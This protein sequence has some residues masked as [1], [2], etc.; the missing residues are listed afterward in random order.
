MP[1]MSDAEIEAD[2]LQAEM[3]VLVIEDAQEL[4]RACNQHALADSLEPFLAD[5]K[6][7]LEIMGQ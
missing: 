1:D 3:N 5:L 2:Y 7:H 6:I 4:L